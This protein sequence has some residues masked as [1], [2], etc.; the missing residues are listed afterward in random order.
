MLVVDTSL[1]PS[2]NARLES[3]AKNFANRL[4]VQ[5]EN[6]ALTFADFY[7]EVKLLSARLQTLIQPGDHVAVQLKRGLDYIVAAY[8]IWQAGGVFLPLD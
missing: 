8:A 5:D 3:T 6:R 7:N 2:L 1:T 4:A